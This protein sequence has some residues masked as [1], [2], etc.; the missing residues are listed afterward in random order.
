MKWKYT[1]DELPIAYQ[2]GEWDGKRSDEVLVEDTEGQKFV[3][4]LYSGFMDGSEF[5]DWFSNYWDYELVNI[6][7]WIKI[8]E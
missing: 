2:E 7:K 1:V 3:A 8:P 6:V 5:N 4:V